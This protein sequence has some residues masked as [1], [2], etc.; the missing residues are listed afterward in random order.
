MNF[1]SSVIAFACVI[2]SSVAF[3]AE[4]SV[5]K[6]E[7][8]FAVVTHKGGI[9]SAFAHD[10]F[11]HAKNFDA[12]IDADS[13]TE[14]GTLEFQVATLDLEV[15]SSE[16]QKK[17]YPLIEK[18]GVLSSPF[19]TPS[20]S[21]RE[22]IR[23]S[24]LADDQLNAKKSPTISAKVEKVEKSETKIG[25]RQYSH[26]FEVSVQIHGKTVKQKVPG[27]IKF[28]GEKLH[29]EALGSFKFTDFGITPFSGVLG[30]VKN[31]DVFEILVSI[32]ADKK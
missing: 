18:L 13:G 27:Y 1:H 19:S 25:E 10:H 11:I 21:D 5:Q 17:W 26:L 30:T 28:E 12:K 3:G 23:K 7:S 14:T 4:Y 15:D 9:A 22:K 8:V 20:E 29:A 31:K 32:K 2:T 6:N 24:M 16:N